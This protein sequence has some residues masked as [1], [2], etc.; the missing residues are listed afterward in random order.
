MQPLP[1]QFLSPTSSLVALFSAQ[2]W[3]ARRQ[4]PDLLVPG[5]GEEQDKARTLGWSGGE[6]PRGG[7]ALG[8]G[9][10]EH[11]AMVVGEHLCVVAWVASAAGQ[12]KNIF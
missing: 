3:A 5:L 2:G 10:G 1:R 7:L 12:G 6:S 11:V 4:S 9:E 8:A